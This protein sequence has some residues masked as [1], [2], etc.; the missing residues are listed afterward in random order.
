[1]ITL[2]KVRN[3]TNNLNNEENKPKRATYINQLFE[4]RAEGKN[5]IWVDETNYNLYCRR[6]QGRSKIGSRASVLVP[7]SK[8]SNLHCIGAMSSN[9]LVLFTTR[10]AF[11]SDD[12]LQ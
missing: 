1:M 7:V 9:S 6:S 10:S 8:G 3:S 12:C 5:L 2:K 11:K 4:N